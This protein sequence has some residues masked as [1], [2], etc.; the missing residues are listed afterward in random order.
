M[1]SGR[2]G[3]IC[4]YERREIHLPRV[5]NQG[6]GRSARRL[7]G[8]CRV[9]FNDT[10]REARGAHSRGE[11]YPGVSVLQKRVL[12]QGKQHPGRAFLG[13]VAGGGADPGGS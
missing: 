8:C 5:P 7:L 10:V 9:V 2:A 4:S 12:T 6:A 11:R 1:T 3:N 13:D